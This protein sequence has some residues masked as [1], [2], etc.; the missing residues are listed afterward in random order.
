MYFL[1]LN[2]MLIMKIKICDVTKHLYYH[3]TKNVGLGLQGS[4][5]QHQYSSMLPENSTYCCYFVHTIT[6]WTFLLYF[7]LRELI[8]K[9]K[10]CGSQQCIMIGQKQINGS[11]SPEATFNVTRRFPINV[12]Y[13]FVH[14]K[15]NKSWYYYYW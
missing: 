7:L 6:F 14:E 1:W 13:Y 15:E 10:V 3:L 12:H 9:V 11:N 5:T 2:V 4:D 8:M